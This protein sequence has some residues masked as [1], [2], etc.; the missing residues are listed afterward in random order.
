MQLVQ[1][2]AHYQPGPNPVITIGTFD[3]VHLG[4]QAIL[5]QLKAQAKAHGG[6]SIVLT[7]WPH[8]RIV[9]G[10]AEGLELLQTF[11][12]RTE[13][14]RQHGI[15]KLVVIEFTKDFAKT[16]HQSF[17]R[18]TLHQRLG[19][20]HVIVGY[21]HRFGSGRA[22]GIDE[23]SAAGQQLGFT[24]EEISAQMVDDANVSSTKIRNALKDGQVAEANTLLGYNYRLSGTVAQGRKLGRTIGYPTANLKPVADYKL[25][26]ARGVYAVAVHLPGGSRWPGM[27]N[28]GY[29][30]TVAEGLARTIEV[31]IIGY[32]G[33][34]YGQVLTL[35][36]LGWLRPEEK[37]DG[38]EALKQ[39]LA[40]DQQA[41]LEVYNR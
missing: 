6:E 29:N 19:A 4:H 28:I 27:L 35:E 37:Y 31:N 2:L 21:D 22:G 5:E 30:P 33:N 20:K 9:L 16:T 34:L 38:M 39:Q 7:F 12:E 8:P 41:A 32:N 1:S 11:E 13:H 26:P 25:V 40:R 15:D 18:E 23:L 10:K 17:I 14:F 3:G 24:V 36:F